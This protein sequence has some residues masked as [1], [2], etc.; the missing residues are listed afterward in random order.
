[1]SPSAHLKKETWFRM[2]YT[3]ARSLQG[4]RFCS[5]PMPN[6][7][8]MLAMEGRKVDSK[9][10]CSYIL[11]SCCTVLFNGYCR[12]CFRLRA[13]LLCFSL[14]FTACFGLHGHLQV[15][16][17]AESFKHM[18]INIW[19]FLHTWRRPCR[20]KHVVKDSE[21]QNT[22]KLHA[23]GNITCDNHCAIC[24]IRLK[25]FCNLYYVRVFCN[26]NSVCCRKFH[27]SGNHYVKAIICLGWHS[28]SQP[29][30]AF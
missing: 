16:S 9:A 22:I 25:L 11:A 1:M 30:T 14:S 23:D 13:T 24:S 12:L 4:L 21:N 10:I 7:K 26:C 19:R 20:P 27:L 28:R 8:N 15:C 6:N 5:L 29:G 2:L 18:K 3:I 17:E